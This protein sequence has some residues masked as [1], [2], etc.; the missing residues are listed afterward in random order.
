MNQLILAGANNLIPIAGG[1]PP[2]WIM[3]MPAGVNPITASY[4]DGQSA[5]LNVRV[6]RDTASTLNAVLAGHL[7]GTQKPYF[8]FSH[9]RLGKASAWPQEMAWRESPAPGVY[10]RVKWSGS[11]AEAIRAGDFRSFSPNFFVGDGDP[12]T[13]T[14]APLYM[15]SLV[16]DPAFR[17]MAPLF[18]ANAALIPEGLIGG[19]PTKENTMEPNTPAAATA[20]PAATVTPA[21]APAPV[22]TA[23]PVVT[24]AAPVAI[25]AAAAPAPAPEMSLNDALA[26]IRRMREGN[27]DRVIQAAIQRGALRPGET[28]VINQYRELAISNPNNIALIEALPTYGQPGQI[29]SAAAANGSARLS[30]EDESLRNKLIGYRDEQNPLARGRFFKKHIQAAM[31]Q[32]DGHDHIMGIVAQRPQTVQ[33]ANTL[34]GLAGILITQQSLAFLKQ[35]LPILTRITTDFS[36]EQLKFNQQLSTRTIA[37]LVANDFDPVNGY[38]AQNVNTTDVNVT[39]NKHKHVTVNFSVVELAS[40]RRLLFKEQEEPMH[41]AIANQFANDVYGLLVPATF[42]NKTVQAQ[43]GFGRTTL[44]AISKLLNTR[45]VRPGNRTA[46]LSS[47][48]HGQ[49]GNDAALVNLAVFQKP[50]LIEG[51]SLPPVAGFTPIEGVTLPNTNN[52]QGA[53]FT[54]DALVLAS[55]L[56]IDYTQQDAGTGGGVVTTVTDPDLGFSVLQVQW[57]NHQLGGTY[58]SLRFMYGVAAGQIASLQLLTSA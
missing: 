54:P 14:G 35:A 22:V 18:A 2:E 57:V 16:N 30:V 50:E 39:L 33:A 8:D 9:N 49:L 26:E 47:A 48:Y 19:Q 32:P 38:V 29:V 34:G 45:G 3:Y 20:T 25:S 6:D 56:P 40:T 41:F 36:A 4:Q 7:A 15:G 43:A 12:A 24:P 42:T 55:R 27:A 51:T 23:T 10:A 44:I 37:Q 11:G 1:E 31:S 5:V 53:F 13:V 21:A 28:G 17:R 46:L 58:M 52:L